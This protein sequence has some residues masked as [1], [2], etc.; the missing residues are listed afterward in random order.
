M[1]RHAELPDFFVDRSLGRITVPQLLRQA[2]LTIVT[3]AERYGIPTDETVT[4]ERW[5]VDAG[6]RSEAILTKDARIRYNRAEKAAI[7]RFRVRCFCLVRQD[8]SANEMAERFV[9]N[10]DRISAACREPGP[11][12]YAV[13]AHRIERLP[14]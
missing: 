9:V 14:L 11:F 3:L 5:L 4:D 12:L 10:L 6:R 13:H 7:E 8:L 1:Q 2:G